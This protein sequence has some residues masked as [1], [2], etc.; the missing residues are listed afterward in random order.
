MTELL[1]HVKKNSTTK[2]ILI[3]DDIK[4]ISRDFYFYWDL[5]KQL[6][7]YGVQPMSPNFIF[8]NTP[9]GRFQQSITV[10]AGEYERESIARQTKQKTKARLEAGYHAFN[11]P[12]GFRFV[13]TRDRG[14]TLTKDEQAATALTEMMEGFASGRFQSKREAK[15]LLENNNDFPK[16]KSGKI[17]NSQV[18]KILSDPLYAGYIEYAPWGVSLRKGQHEGIIDLCTFKK[19]Q[20]RLSIHA[21]VPQKEG[22][23]EDFPLRDAVA[24]E[25]G[26]ALTAAW[27]RSATGRLYAYYVCQNRN[28]EFKGKSIRKELIEGQFE[29]FLKSLTPERPVFTSTQCMFKKL[30]ENESAKTSD[31]RSKLEAEYAKCESDINTALTRI[32]ESSNSAVVSAFEKRIESLETE[33]LLI[34]EK[35]AKCGSEIAPSDEMYRTSLEFLSNPHKL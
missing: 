29:E 7:V 24:Y 26:N 5:I 2:Y 1:Q 14:K 15:R 4:R 10:V 18:G 32:L 22:I 35:I 12:V 3:L 20:K 17:G 11:A 31:N 34:Q 30:W 16:G 8:A 19:I 13:K 9:E 27:S 23:K 33:K 25:C 6:D 28:C 21:H